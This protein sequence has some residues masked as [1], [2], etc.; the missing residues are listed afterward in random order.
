MVLLCWVGM[1][2]G[3]QSK[4]TS[5][6][7]EETLLDGMYHSISPLPQADTVMYAIGNTELFVRIQGT[8]PTLV[9]VHGGPGLSHHYL[10]PS[11]D[12][13][14]RSY[15]LVYYDQRLSGLSAPACDTSDIT[16]QRWVEDLE[17]L[18]EKLGVDSMILLS[19]S[20]GALVAMKYAAVHSE[21]LAGLVFLNPVAAEPG[22]VQQAS[23][24][25]QERL[26]SV[27][28]LTREKLIRSQEFQ[29]GEK[30]AILAAYRFSFAQSVFR[31]SV[32]D[33]LNL[34]IPDRSITR[35]QHLSYLYKDQEMQIYNYYIQL[36]QVHSPTLV[37]HGSYDATPV[38][39]SEKL[40]ASLK[41]ELAVIQDS[42][43]FSFLETPE[44]M[45]N[46]LEKF[47]NGLH[48]THKS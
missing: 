13:L 25:L 12:Y 35:Q 1:F 39:A 30:Q 29:N 41:G 11:L 8:G 31:R 47:L 20:W 14:S 48:N 46:L 9:V 15:R 21:H 37:I 27:D 23:A 36:G 17:E 40:A 44:E 43:H 19:H 42:G 3:C 16:L 24:R 33:S 38:E 45:A 18:R 5:T 28:Q 6:P 22:Y 26:T 7:S 4:E 34:F 2:S 10:R 32:L